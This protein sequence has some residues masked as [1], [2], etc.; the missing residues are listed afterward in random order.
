MSANGVGRSKL[1][2]IATLCIS[3]S[4]T[5]QENSELVEVNVKLGVIMPFL[6]ETM[7]PSN[8]ALTP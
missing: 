2:K 5:W 7:D 1:A 6:I 4:T 3:R 8:F